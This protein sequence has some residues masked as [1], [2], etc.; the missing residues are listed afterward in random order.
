MGSAIREYKKQEKERRRA[1]ALKKSRE[2]HIAIV[3]KVILCAQLR[4]LL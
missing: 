3:Q 1:E 4:E 2:Q